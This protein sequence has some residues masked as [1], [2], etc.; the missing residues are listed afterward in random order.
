MGQ[1]E[2]GV[3][4]DVRLPIDERESVVNSDEYRVRAA[5]ETEIPANGM[6]C[7]NVGVTPSSKWQ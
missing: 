2:A 3:L 1:E 4:S 5:S 6:D 7:S